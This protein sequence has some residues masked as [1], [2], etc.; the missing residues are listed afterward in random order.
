MSTPKDAPRAADCSID[1]VQTLE[2]NM[3]LG[4][5][6]LRNLQKRAILFIGGTGAGKTTLALLCGGYRLKVIRKKH[7]ELG[8]EL[9]DQD[10]AVLEKNFVEELK[11]HYNQEA[12]P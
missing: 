7:N 4:N 1:K 11:K 3:R 9:T 6:R 8:F 10:G 12:Q 2:K 5:S